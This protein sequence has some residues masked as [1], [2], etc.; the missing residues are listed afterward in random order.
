M[1]RYKL[2]IDYIGTNYCGWQKQPEQNSIQGTLEKV[3]K[4][5]LQEDIIIHGQGR[6]DSG[7]HALEQTAHFDTTG[8]I[9]LYKLKHAFLGLLPDDIAVWN[10]EQVTEQFHARFDAVSRTY[11]YRILT[12]PHSHLRTTSSLTLKPL[13]I[14]KLKTCAGFVVGKHDFIKI[15]RNDPNH[16]NYICTIDQSEWKVNDYSLEYYIRSNR[17]LRHM[18]RRLVGTMLGCAKGK[19]PV[20]AFKALIN[21][22]KT[23]IKPHMA[24]AKG[25][26]LIKVNY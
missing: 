3:L 23:S 11:K 18:V 19:Y 24:E 8:K 1:P 12:R 21:N 26:T 5:V 20:N 13:P 14:N 25:L 4:Q 10:I 16:N 2:Y 9:D 6:T 7:V 15:A 17:F 22:E